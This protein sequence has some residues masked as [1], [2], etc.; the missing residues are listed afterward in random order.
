MLGQEDEEMGKWELLGEVNV[1]D[2]TGSMDLVGVS[3][4][5]SAYK[6]FRVIAVGIRDTG[7]QSNV[8]ING[9]YSS[10]YTLTKKETSKYMAMDVIIQMNDDIGA[11][12]GE[13]FVCGSTWG[14]YS[15]FGGDLTNY[16]RLTNINPNIIEAIKAVNK[17]EIYSY[18]APWLSGT[19]AQF[20]GMK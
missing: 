10:S 4:D 15:P 18:N 7:N 20:Y 14:Q 6:K 19:R 11:V 16:C 13:G 9:L 2:D 12:I 1:T 5:F 3:G 8:T 17:I